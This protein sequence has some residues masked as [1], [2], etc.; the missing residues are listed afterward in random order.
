VD[1]IVAWVLFPLVL[2]A[3]C[4]CCGLLVERVSGRAMATPLLPLA[5][6]CAIVVAGQ[7]LCLTDATAGWTTPAICALALS[8]AALGRNRSTALEPLALATA[9]AVVCV[10]AAPVA[11]SGEPTIAGFI[12]LDDTATWLA[13]TDRLVDHGRDLGGL[14]PSSYEAT[15]AFNLGDGYPVGAFIPFGAAA[16]LIPADPAWLIQPYIA[17]C[18]GLLALALWSLARPLERSPWLR[19]AAAF[20]AAQSALLFGYALWGGVKEVIAAALVAGVAA[21]AAT[22]IERP[23]EP[24]GLAATVLAAAALLGVLSG[25]GLI[26]LAP[27]LVAAAVVVAARAGAGYA[28]RLSLGC[29]AGIAALSAP[30]PLS[31]AVVPPTSSPLTDSTARGNLAGPLDPLQAAG[32]W[33]AGDFRFDPELESLAL[34]LI[35]IACVLAIAGIAWSLRRREP[36]PALYAA[37]ALTACAVIAAAGSPWVGA[38]ALAIA[39]PAIPFAAMLGAGW[40]AAAGS[41]AVAAGLAAVLAAGVIWSNAL[42]Y[43]G[44]NLAPRAQLAEL[45]RIGELVEG[46]GPALMTEY[47]PYGVRHFLRESDP[48]SVSELRRRAIALRDGGTVPKG[49]FADTDELDPRALGLYRTLVLRR[50]PARSRP[51]SPYRRVWS[52]DTYEAWQRPAQG[53]SPPLRLPLGAGRDPYGVPDCRRVLELARAG[54]LVAAGGR[55]PLVIGL[56][57]ASYPAAWAIP[58]S[59]DAPVP[60]EPGTLEAS[61]E[62]ERA[63]EYEVWLRGSLRPAAELSI[64]G[65]EVGEVRH[66]LNNRGGQISFGRVALAPG[67]HQLA[68]EVG[69]ADLHP[70]SAGEAG[71]VGPLA[72]APAGGSEAALVRVPAARARELCGRPWDWI[73]VTG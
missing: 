51:P 53:P 21:F 33:P 43:G 41:R 58:G 24:R 19:A 46:E 59:R 31:G 73:E 45:E 49:G 61:F 65:E 12:K 23:R 26:W 8:G 66:E 38:K 2:L 60:R 4:G 3:L 56:A 10:Y 7:F 42:G 15:L 39:S 32:I 57:S 5:G 13:L 63:D 36:R 9:A 68:L 54:D 28:L 27:P 1:L 48:E 52:G 69:G 17:F 37:G 6:L 71:P 35:A 50:S 62:V 44:V 67:E 20:V 22:A 11:L 72:L 14:A 55:R 40:L 34:A 64:D 16:A 18:A 29:V 70:G 30:L 47:S 25:G